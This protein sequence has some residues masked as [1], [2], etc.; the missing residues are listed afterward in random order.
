MKTYLKFASVLLIF[1]LSQ[2]AFA[3]HHAGE[4]DSCKKIMQEKQGM[5][6][7]DLNKNGVVSRDEFTTASLERAE[8]TFEHIDANKD[9]KLDDEEQKA[10]NA[11]W[12]AQHSM[13]WHNMPDDPHHQMPNDAHHNLNM[14]DDENHQ[15]P[16]DSLLTM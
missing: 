4:N 13:G 12:A 15:M 1:V 7:M 6:D 14:P 10:A 11:V 8:K 16:K 3:D 2:F 5:Q 9:G